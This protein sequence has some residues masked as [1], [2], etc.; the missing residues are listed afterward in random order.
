[1][2]EYLRVGACLV[3]YL[4]V[5]FRDLRPVQYLVGTNRGTTKKMYK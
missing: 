3:S 1:M 4:R 5:L 2:R